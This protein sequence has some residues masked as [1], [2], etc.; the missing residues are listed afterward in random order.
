MC[1]PAAQR[2][3]ENAGYI[4][5]VPNH[6][7]EHSPPIFSRVF[8]SPL[9]Q[10]KPPPA[11]G[12]EWNE[13]LVLANGELRAREAGTAHI[14]RNVQSL[15]EPEGLEDEARIF[16]QLNYTKWQHRWNILTWWYHDDVGCWIWIVANPHFFLMEDDH[17]TDA[18]KAL[19]WVGNASKVELW[20]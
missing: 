18:R 16:G 2:Y 7:L 9:T 3:C 4:E 17:A 15:L 6:S 20:K 10:Q 14:M 19:V 12:R 13:L 11:D 5:K 1:C 8:P